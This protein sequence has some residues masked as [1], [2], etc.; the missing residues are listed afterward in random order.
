MG[1]IRVMNF[2]SLDGVVQSVLSADED[3]DGGFE[4]G[5]WV[6]ALMDDDVARIMAEATT[7]ASAMLLGRRTYEGFAAIWPTAD[8]SEPPVA[9]MNR[10]EKYVVSR[11]LAAADWENTTVLSD[12]ADVER[13]KARIDGDILVFGS[14]VLLQSLFR[15]GLVDEI[16]LLIFPLVIGSGKKM[17]PDGSQALSLELTGGELTSNGV[18][19]HR[20]TV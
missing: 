16:W 2:V 11:T 19:V 13:I 17:F 18:A 14:S 5:G 10:M 12:P 6:S 8:Q 9:A 20:Y 4:A 15:L 1:T 7:A 3:R